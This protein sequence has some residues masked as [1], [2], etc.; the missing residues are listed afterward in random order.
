MMV[1]AKCIQRAWDSTQSRLYVPD[2][3]PLPG[4]LYELDL[5]NPAHRK[6]ADLKTQMR[7]FVFQFDRVAANDPASGLYFCSDCGAR[8]ETLNL[9]GTHTRQEH[10]KTLPK[11]EPEP[12]PEV[13]EVPTGL[14]AAGD[15]RGLV[16][17]HCKGCGQEFPNVNVLTKH[18]PSCPGAPFTERPLERTPSEPVA[19]AASEEMAQAPP[20]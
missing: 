17:I 10:K 5:E 16:P 18:K 3:G 11:P 4:G 8:F 14:N 20:A 12:E 1:Q 13:E 9:L 2:G 7:Q 6:L 19:P 15:L